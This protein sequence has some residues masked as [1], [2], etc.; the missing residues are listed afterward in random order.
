MQGPS[1]NVPERSQLTLKR[2]DKSSAILILILILIFRSKKGDDWEDFEDSDIAHHNSHREH[3]ELC[4]SRLVSGVSTVCQPCTK[5]ALLRWVHWQAGHVRVNLWRLPR[6]AVILLAC[7][8]STY[9]PNPPWPT[10]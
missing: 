1:L 5:Y 3:F 10:T 6:A 4:R 9:P 2:L 8:T 7:Y